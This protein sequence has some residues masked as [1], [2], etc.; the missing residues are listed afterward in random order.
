MRLFFLLLLATLQSC[1]QSNKNIKMESYAQYR[2]QQIEARDSLF[3][4]HTVKEWGKKNWYTFEDYSKMYEMTND[5][6]EYFIGAVFYS[7]DKTKI[8]VWIGDRKPNAKTT[9]VYNKEK[10]Q[11]NKLCPNGK[12]R[13]CSMSALIGI[14]DSANQIWKLYPFN[15]QQA[16]CYDTKEEVINVLG[17]YYFE[18]MKSHQMYRMIQTGK[19]K[20]YRELQAYGYN[21]QDKDFWNKCWIWQKDTVGSYGLYPFQIKSYDCDKDNY[22]IISDT[23]PDQKKDETNGEY[24][25]RNGRIERKPLK[26]KLK[27]CAEPYSPPIIEY[28]KEILELYNH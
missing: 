6:V 26:E 3:I 5:Q 23:Y 12:D 16:T 4:L 9:V 24:V 27:D 14:R 20:G 1:G 17:Q 7:P 25:A 19:K 22:Q 21:L 15:Q 8:L 18:K 13:V 28:P 10:P 11:V 2:T